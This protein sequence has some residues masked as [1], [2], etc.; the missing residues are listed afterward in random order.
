MADAKINSA[1]PDRLPVSAFGYWLLLAVSVASG[2]YALFISGPAVRAA[3]QEQLGR[4]IANE[5][6]AVCVKFGF[7]SGSAE[8]AACSGEL[9]IVRRK[10]TE[11]DKA[12]TMGIL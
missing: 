3:A 5:D 1:S 7:G 2:L 8:F 9:A 11:R 6:R 4:S 12:E 10:Q